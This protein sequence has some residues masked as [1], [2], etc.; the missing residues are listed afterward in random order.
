VLLGPPALRPATGDL[1]LKVEHLSPA[2]ATSFAQGF[3]TLGSYVTGTL[4]YLD[5]TASLAVL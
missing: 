5:E 2:D 3:G 4:E 1:F